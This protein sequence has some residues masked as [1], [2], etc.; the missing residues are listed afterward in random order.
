MDNDEA[1]DDIVDIF[2]FDHV[3]TVYN[4]I[5]PDRSHTVSGHDS[6]EQLDESSLDDVSLFIFYEK[7]NLTRTDKYGN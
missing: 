5:T 1:D 4:E 6:A 7:K 3:Q 2:A